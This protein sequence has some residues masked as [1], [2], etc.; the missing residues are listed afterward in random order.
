MSELLITGITVSLDIKTSDFGTGSSNFVSFKAETTRRENDT[1]VE[2]VSLEE[3][4]R[5]SLDMH[6]KAYE[7]IIS[8]RVGGSAM[9][10]DEFKEAHDR[11]LKR[12]RGARRHLG[13]LKEEN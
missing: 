6:L 8:A 13:L 2:G 7:S 3:A 4:L 12:F 5:V 10:G 9:S 11:A 1:L